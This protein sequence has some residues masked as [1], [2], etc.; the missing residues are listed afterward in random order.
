MQGQYYVPDFQR[1]I[2]VLVFGPWVLEESAFLL[3]LFAR[4]FHDHKEEPLC[5][6]LSQPCRQ[7]IFDGV[8]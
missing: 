2:Q 6:D 8:V 3:D 4:D 7:D 5:L 1:L